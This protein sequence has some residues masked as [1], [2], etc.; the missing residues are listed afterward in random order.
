[1]KTQKNS[2][3]ALA[4][5]TVAIDLGLPLPGLLVLDGLSANAGREGYD[6]DRVVDLYRLVRRT[7][8]EYK[9][10]LQVITVD[11]DLPQAIE[12]ELKNLIVLTLSQRDRL[13][14][15]VGTDPSL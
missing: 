15:V 10:F 6:G 5:H 4:H 11:N 2:A 12:G 3:H 7:A 9:D 1:N 14:R 8:E 13:I